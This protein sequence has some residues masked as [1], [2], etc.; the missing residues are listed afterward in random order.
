MA[1][2]GLAVL[3][4]V[5]LVFWAARIADSWGAGYWP[6]ATAT[7]AA[8][9]VLALTRRTHRAGTAAAGLAVAA[10]AVLVARVAGLPSEPGP[11]T[12]LGLSVLVC[13]AVRTAPPRQAATVGAACVAV[14]AASLVTTSHPLADG[15]PPVTVL[16]GLAL[17]A[18]AGAGLALRVRHDLR[19]AAIARVRRD[20][21]LELARELHDVVAHHITGVVLETQAARIALRSRP[22]TLDESLAGIETASTDALAAMR[23]VVGLLRDTEDAAPAT[24][25]P[26]ALG[27]LVDRFTR[28]GPPVRLSVPG[29]AASGGWRP[30]VTSTVHR[31]VQESL[32]NI[33]RHAAHATA[34]TVDVVQDG[35]SVTV[36]VADD[37][38]A[39]PARH[40]R[41]G[42][43]LAGLRERVEALDGTLSAGP[44][45]GGGW[46]V[47]ARIP[48]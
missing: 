18:G 25:G 7:G 21:R 27:E 43:G 30:E 8:V 22:E 48:A 19:D 17:A 37:A 31:V 14:T 12:A 45:P 6:F 2:V 11:A 38:T 44:R 13:S 9:C 47:R 15:V 10:V 35:R 16:T 32:T 46:S 40:H 33:A 28:H 36:E 29:P 20:E 3:A 24:A 39:P 26:E 34:V 1:D 4:A 41:A 23:R 42:Y 5:V